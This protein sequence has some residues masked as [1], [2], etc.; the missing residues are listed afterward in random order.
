MAN[1][2]AKQRTSKFDKWLN[3]PQFQDRLQGALCGWMESEEFI[4]QF[5]IACMAD[6]K[7]EKCTDE[8]KFKAAHLCAAL[9]LMPSLGHV[10]LIPR[11]IK[12]A[13]GRKTGRFKMSVM[14]QWQGYK[15]IMERYPNVVD[16]AAELVF[17]GECYKRF[18]DGSFEHDFD[19][20]EERRAK[21]DLSNVKGGYLRILFND[22]RP[23]KYH[24]V[25]KK[26]I[27]KA[28]GCAESDAFWGKWTHEQCL[29]S[30]IRNGYARRVVTIDTGI[31]AVLLQR[32]AETDDQAM[33]NDP[34]RVVG[35]SARA[36]PV[37]NGRKQRRQRQLNLEPELPEEEAPSEPEPQAQNPKKP[38]EPIATEPFEARKLID[39]TAKCKT[40]GAVDELA[41]VW[42][43][44]HPDDQSAIMEICLV[45]REQFEADDESRPSGAEGQLFET[46]SEGV[47]N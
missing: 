8:S 28:R 13:N 1:E 36:L 14:P 38:Q 30:V 42:L 11:E 40:A 22:G 37:A 31:N 45:A 23:I 4:S 21:R 18:T 27:E 7:L 10:A 41:E 24:F 19:P 25:T 39:E 34:G 43:Q 2:V 46:E 16:V 12:D 44:R 26:T 35:S 33:G 15:A 17:E 6:W 9:Q 20:F 47:G 29:K 3:N 5:A 32:L